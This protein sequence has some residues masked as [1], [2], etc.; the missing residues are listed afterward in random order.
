LFDMVCQLVQSQNRKISIKLSHGYETVGPLSVSGVVLMNRKMKAWL[1]H[2]IT[3]LLARDSHMCMLDN[4][5]HTVLVL[6]FVCFTT[7]LARVTSTLV[8]VIISA[9]RFVISL[10]Y[11]FVS[12]F[13]FCIN[14]INIVM[15]FFEQ[16]IHSLENYKYISL[17]I[18]ELFY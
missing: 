14:I 16:K 13:V 10:L 3:A 7:G 11:K 5:Q 9:T 4:T 15:L 12:L 8:I 2:R 17:S 18:K 6:N 1:C